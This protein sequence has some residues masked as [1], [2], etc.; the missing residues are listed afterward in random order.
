MEAGFAVDVMMNFATSANVQ[1][2]GFITQIRHVFGVEKEIVGHTKARL[3]VPIASR[4]VTMKVNTKIWIR[5]IGEHE[6]IT[7]RQ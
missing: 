2:L 3:F 4:K 5:K 6:C 1:M 7:P